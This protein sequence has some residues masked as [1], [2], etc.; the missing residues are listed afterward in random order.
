MTGYNT[1]S[2]AALISILIMVT[3]SR[4]VQLRCKE[5]IKC[6]EFHKCFLKTSYTGEVSSLTTGV[7]VGAMKDPI[8]WLTTFAAICVLTAEVKSD[9]KS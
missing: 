7:N 3:A 6:T 1:L 4:V 9:T 8:I 2:F 5:R